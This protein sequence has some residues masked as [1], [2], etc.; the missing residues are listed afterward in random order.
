V[1]KVTKCEFAAKFVRKRR[2]NMPTSRIG[3][4]REQILQEAEILEEIRH[5]NIIDVHE[6]FET[7]KEIILVLEL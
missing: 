5:P 2:K 6:V 4:P 1:E 7:E 3:L